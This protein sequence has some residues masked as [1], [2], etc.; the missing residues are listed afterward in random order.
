[1]TVPTAAE[2]T[3]R[4]QPDLHSD[5]NGSPVPAQI[6]DPYNVTQL[7]PDLYQ[8]APIPNAIIPNPNQYALKMYSFYPAPN[9][10]PDD[11]ITQT[12]S[13]RAR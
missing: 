4:L 13:G 6:F 8:R 5:A 12:I 2:A 10:T 1:M 3:G 7:G 11:A 9:R